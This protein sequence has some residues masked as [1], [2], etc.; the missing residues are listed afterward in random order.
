MSD[1]TMSYKTTNLIYFEEHLGGDFAWFVCEKSPRAK[2]DFSLEKSIL[3]PK[4]IL[5]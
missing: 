2:K 3:F 1:I 4:N 5:G